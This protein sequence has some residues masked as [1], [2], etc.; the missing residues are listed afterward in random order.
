MWVREM[1]ERRAMPAG[2]E[3]SS[4]K[5]TDV[6]LQAIVRKTTIDVSNAM[7]I[8]AF[9]GCVNAICNTIATVPIYLYEKK[10][11][12]VERRD[13]ARE[14]LLNGDTRDTLTGADFKR[15]LVFD[16]LTDIG[17]YAYINRRGT[18]WLSLNYVEPSKI[19]I[20]ESV[21]P[22]FKD[23]SLLVHGREFRPY[24]FL[25][26]IRRTKN[27]YKGISIVDESRDLLGTAYAYVMFEQK[28][29][30][31]GGTK[32]GFLQAE[33]KLKQ[34]E[35]NLLR[36][37]FRNLY[38]SNDEN[39]VVLNNG[40]KFQ[41]AASTSVE[42][43]LNENKKTMSNDICKLFMIPPEIINGAATDAQKKLFIQEAIVPILNV[44]CT[45]LNRDLLLERE[46]DTLFFAPDLT[47]L[48]QGDIKARF[49]A[50][51]IAADKGIMQIDEIRKKE[52]LP[53]LEMPFIKLG[54]QDVLYD[55]KTGDIY[56]PNTNSW[57]SVKKDAGKPQEGGGET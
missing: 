28:L 50:W 16:Y 53:A 40:I 24:Q 49:E 52:N 2:L 1:M 55:P 4:L 35:I 44:M 37:A 19:S 18:H 15:A 41:P 47:E 7:S 36:Q 22:I 45:S 39:I 48:T 11:N 29:V 34:E 20:S 32:K 54:L 12:A 26:V 10:N 46:K 51:G 14:R 57:G 25:K 3:D 17:G 5:L 33:N 21:D 23:Y 43:Q 30:T 9:A 27:G 6:L 56:T 8:P 38:G 42:M 13:D 31:S